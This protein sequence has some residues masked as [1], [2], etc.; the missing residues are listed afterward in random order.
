VLNTRAPAVAAPL[1]YLV[2]CARL[3]AALLRTRRD[4]LLLVEGSPVDTLL[5][6]SGTPPR[7]SGWR[8]LTRLCGVRTPHIHLIRP[9]PLPATALP[10]AEAC[11]DTEMFRY[12]SGRSPT[13]YLLFQNSDTP[14]AAA[15][16][17]GR[18]IERLY[19]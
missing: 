18:I 4:R 1:A 6:P 15:D 3:R 8:W 13:D 19:L 11:Y 14:E 16:A 17:L 12:F 10:Q 9:A 5:R 7:W 2:F